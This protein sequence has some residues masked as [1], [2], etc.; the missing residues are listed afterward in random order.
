MCARLRLRLHS[1]L[2]HVFWILFFLFSCWL[3]SLISSNGHLPKLA[4]SNDL[5]SILEDGFRNWNRTQKK[6]PGMEFA[7]FFSFASEIPAGIP[8][9]GQG[10]F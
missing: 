10:R 1:L 9:F 2:L 7:A 3:N 4:V 8:Y 6:L 5:Q